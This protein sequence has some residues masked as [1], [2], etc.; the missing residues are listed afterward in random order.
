MFTFSQPSSLLCDHPLPKDLTPTE[1]CGL[2]W[3]PPKGIFGDPPQE[4]YFIGHP[5]MA[6]F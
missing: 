6:F 1:M 2:K 4:H 5:S 3:S